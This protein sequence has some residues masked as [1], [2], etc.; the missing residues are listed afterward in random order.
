MK[1]NKKYLLLIAGSV[2]MIA[3]INILNIGSSVYGRYLTWFN[4]LL[5]S[6]VFVI[7]HTLIFRRMVKKHTVRITAYKENYQPFY[8]FF[9]GSSYLIMAVM[10]SCGIGLR[11]FHLIS[12]RFVAVFYTGLG[13]ALILAGITFGISFIHE[14]K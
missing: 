13:A 10:M 7:F 8:Q 12:D 2:W 14:L 5:T 11:V 4:A 6:V 9:D 3:G 1:I